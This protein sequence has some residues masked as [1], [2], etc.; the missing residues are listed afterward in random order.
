[1]NTP[2]LGLAVVGAGRIGTLRA[3]LAAVQAAPG[4][5]HRKQVTVLFAD[6][7]GSME[8]AAATSAVAPSCRAAY[9]STRRRPRSR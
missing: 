4:G 2:G 6:V 9:R 3:R 7:V 8:I 1:M 5:P